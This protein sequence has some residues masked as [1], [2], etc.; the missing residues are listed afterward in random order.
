MNTLLVGYKAKDLFAAAKHG[1]TRTAEWASADGVVA[2]TLDIYDRHA[3]EKTHHIKTLCSPHLPAGRWD[4]VLFRTGPKIMSGELSLDLL[5]EIYALL[6][7]NMKAP[8]FV[9]DFVGRSATESRFSKRFPQKACG[10]GRS[11][12]S[13]RRACRAVL[14]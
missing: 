6:G 4:K 10:R 12:R 7:G 5:Q 9:L 13:G 3:I 2:H 11:R 1:R 14:K 8:A